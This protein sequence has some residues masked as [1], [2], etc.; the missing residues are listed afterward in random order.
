MGVDTGGAGDQGMMFGYACNENA[1][2]DASPDFT[3]AQAH[4]E[5]FRSPQEWHLPLPSSR[6]KIPSH[7]RI[8][9]QGKVKRVDAVVVSTQHSETVGNDELRADILKHV[10]QAVIPAHFSM[11]TPSTTSI[12]PD[13]SSSAAPWA[14]PV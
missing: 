3:R 2:T 9:L 7:S 5:T 11:K 8:R 10:I 1:G 13:A 12:P 14:I 4:P 6:R